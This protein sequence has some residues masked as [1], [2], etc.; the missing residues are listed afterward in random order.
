MDA[1]GTRMLEHEG[2]FVG[3][4]ACVLRGGPVWAGLLAAE[5][6]DKTVGIV[7]EVEIEAGRRAHGRGGD[8]GE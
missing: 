5:H 3:R 4:R 1:Q 7:V 8:D 2:K 6:G